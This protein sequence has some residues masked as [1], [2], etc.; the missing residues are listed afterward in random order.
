[1]S[2]S[3]M[4]EL[5]K[6]GVDVFCG[7]VA[8]PPAMQK[9]CENVDTVFHV[10]AKVGIWGKREEFER[11]N[12]GGARALVDACRTNNVERIVFTSSPSVVF[13]D[14][15]LSGADETQPLGTNFPA[16]YPRTKAEAERI[17]LSANAPGSLATVSL[18]PHLIWGV[19]DHH[20]IPRVVKRAKQGR[21]RIVGVGRNK[22]DLTHVENVVDAHILAEAAT[23]CPDSP[24]H[25]KAYFITNGEPVVLW[26]WINDLLDRLDISPVSKHISLASAKRLGATCET[27]WRILGLQSDPPMTRFAASELAKDH[28]FEIGAA[29]RDLGYS[30]RVTMHQGLD[31]LIPW[32][33]QQFKD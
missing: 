15:D 8:D 17:I 32:L 27:I 4:S 10:A 26:D 25:G 7:D 11:T 3:S 2:R 16:D 19:G 9:A 28:W 29:R 23:R 14:S 12:V 31:E 20:L 33:R 30:P 13:N 22:V 1:M 5:G 21:L 24:A 18:R 6:L